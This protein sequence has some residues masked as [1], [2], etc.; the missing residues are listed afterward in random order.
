[1]S[2]YVGQCMYASVSRSVC[3]SQCIYR[4]V[5]IYIYIYIIKGV[6]YGFRVIN[7]DCLASYHAQ[8]KRIRSPVFR[9]LI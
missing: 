9:K 8:P 2:V 5:Y 4:S 6:V 1:M 3:I 7:D